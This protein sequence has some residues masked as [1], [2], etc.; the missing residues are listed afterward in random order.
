MAGS[1]ELGLA[2][3]G[4]GGGDLVSRALVLLE[5]GQL[6]AG[7]QVLAADQEPHVRRSGRVPVPADGVAQ[8]PGQLRDL[9]VFPGLAVGVGRRR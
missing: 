8:Q 6:G 1:G 9:R 7:V 4:A 2:G 5:Q 3:G